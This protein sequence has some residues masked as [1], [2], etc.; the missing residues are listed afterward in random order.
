VT[1]TPRNVPQV[2]YALVA[3]PTAPAKFE[4]GILN[5]S[6]RVL[7]LSSE[8]VETPI[9]VGGR[10]NGHPLD[11]AAMEEMVATYNP[12]AQP[13][14]IKLTHAEVEDEAKKKAFGWVKALRIGDWVPP[15]AKR[16]VKTLFATLSFTEEG[17][18]AVQSGAYRM[19][20]LEAWP[21]QHQSNPTPGKWNFRALALLG[22]ES[23]GCP[24][25]T[26]LTLAAGDEDIETPVLALQAEE[27]P[28]PNPGGP[29]PPAT[30][31]VN[32]TPEELAALTAKAGTATA[33]EAENT[34]L[35]AQLAA[36]KAATDA[37]TVQ[38]RL[39]GLVKDGKLTPA[40]AA[41]AKPVLL[42]VADEG[43]VTL[44]EGKTST[45][46]QALFSLLEGLKGHGLT[47][48]LQVPHTSPAQ[49]A[50]DD[51]KAFDAAVAKHK[52]AGK[53]H[54]EAVHLAAQECE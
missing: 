44:A 31:G 46:R 3:A 28:T 49:L 9:L 35:M 20:S 23:P 48:P 8:P 36:A 4:N 30:H 12:E 24:N 13:A 25:L 54:D 22:A 17:R 18:Q 51:A 6:K 53:S 10:W 26:P 45:P 50:T 52:A 43:A 34:K 47:T 32:M 41:L 19:K 15:G 1:P 29:Q 40:Q 27:T 37:T 11:L 5:A 2:R 38:A 7:A 42:S 14:P 33:L 21:R 16:A 39:E